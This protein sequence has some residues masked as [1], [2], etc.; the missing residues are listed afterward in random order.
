M[1]DAKRLEW[2]IN[3]KNGLW[4]AARFPFGAA[5]AC[6]L[7]LAALLGV[8]ALGAEI[9][10]KDYTVPV[11]LLGEGTAWCARYAED[12]RMISVMEAGNVIEGED[13][14]TV[15]AKIFQVDGGMKPLAEARTIYFTGWQERQQCGDVQLKAKK[16]GAAFAAYDEA[17]KLDETHAAPASLYVGRG[18]ARIQAGAEARD[19]T[20]DKLEASKE[21][22]T[23][24]KTLDAAC[25]GA[26]LGLADVSIREGNIDGDGGAREILEEGL[27][28]TENDA[29]VQAKLDQIVAGN[30]SDSSG[31]EHR[32][33]FFEEGTGLVWYY[34]TVYDE[35]GR[36]KTS[37][38]F[39]RDGQEI[40]HID[41]VYDAAGQRLVY[42]WGYSSDGTLAKAIQEFNENGQVIS[43]IEQ[44]WEDGQWVD[45]E[46]TTYEY[47]DQGRVV[48][49]EMR[50]PYWTGE[51][52][53][54]K[55][56]QVYD[57]EDH[58]LRLEYY[59]KDGSLV[60]HSEYAYDEAGNLTLRKI[61]ENGMLTSHEEFAYNEAGKRTEH[62]EYKQDTMIRYIQW[63]YNELG[64]EV[65]ERCYTIPEGDESGQF[66]V[67]WRSKSYYS[68]DGKQRIKAEIYGDGETLSYYEQWIYEGSKLVRS[69]VREADGTL[70]SWETYS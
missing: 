33:S 46:R 13:G 19:L 56:V 48:T 39:D 51:A 12:G 49:T 27:A 17:V 58:R 54:F 2:L 47:T 45:D 1:P 10:V 21:D 4:T 11:D 59:D 5:A 43:R 65:E 44:K 69:E 14:R 25:A 50:I 7:G 68:E 60:N 70:K 67:T 40:C 30:V 36:E 63:D 8:P 18:D 53:A 24:A 52:S 3:M 38:S 64:K 37:T 32:H 22:Y 57:T 55:R 42:R 9:Q 35:K 23:T 6:A 31:H 28:A 34:D 20:V 66:K 41:C 61:Y 15:L 62:R 16:Y 29:G 26:Y